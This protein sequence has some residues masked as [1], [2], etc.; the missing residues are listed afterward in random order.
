M[1]AAAVAAAATDSMFCLS[2]M[3]SNQLIENVTVICDRGKCDVPSLRGL[4]IDKKL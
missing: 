4:L 1:L 3:H 2:V